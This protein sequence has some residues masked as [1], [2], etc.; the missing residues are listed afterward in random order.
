VW[1]TR[2]IHIKF[3]LLLASLET[4][5]EFGGNPLHVRPCV[6]TFWHDPNESHLINLITDND[7][8]VF[9]N[10][11]RNS[12]HFF[13]HYAYEWT[14]ASTVDDTSSY[15]CHSTF[16]LRKQMRC[17]FWSLCPLWKQVLPP[18]RFLLLFCLPE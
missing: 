15:W 2:M 18:C 8:S 5:H 6:N 11:S 4:R 17:C 13:I 9:M 14:S 16:D 7:A 10:T 3:L 1:Q 12:C